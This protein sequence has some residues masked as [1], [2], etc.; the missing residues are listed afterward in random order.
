MEQEKIKELLGKYFEG[1]TSEEE[2]LMLKELVKSSSLQ[3]TF[4]EEFGY[5]ASPPPIIPEPSEGFEDR[6]EGVTHVTATIRSPRLRLAWL[7]AISAAV[8][9]IAGIWILYGIFREPRTRDTFSDPVI[10]MAE[11]KNILFSV[12]ERMN[13][14]T[15]QLQQVGEFA[16][17]PDELEGL[18]AINNLVGKNLSR[19][20]YLGD[21]ESKENKTETD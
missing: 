21:L 16:H 15:S 9:V 7:T 2:E 3:E 13:A 19:L 14:G 4:G 17:R 10:A 1:L 6:L 12:S 20:R 5:L 11:V 8:A 18:S